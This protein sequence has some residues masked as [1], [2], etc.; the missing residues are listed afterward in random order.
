M[1]AAFGVLVSTRTELA[2][3][4]LLGLATVLVVTSAVEMTGT[5]S[6]V[7][8]PFTGLED[9]WLRIIEVSSVVTLVFVPVDVV[10]AEASEAITGI[11]V[12]TSVV[13]AGEV[14]CGRLVVFADTSTTSELKVDI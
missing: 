5:V 6:T 3:F 1:L 4:K 13:M 14:C 12:G 8:T 10:G 7:V 2:G 11:V 9:A